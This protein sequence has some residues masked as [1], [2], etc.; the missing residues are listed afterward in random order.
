MLRCASVVVVCS[1]VT[2]C[3]EGCP[4]VTADE[5]QISGPSFQVFNMSADILAAPHL[6]LNVR[7]TRKVQRNRGEGEENEAET[8]EDEE[9]HADVWP[10]KASKSEI[11]NTVKG[12][13]MLIIL[14]FDMNEN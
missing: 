12:K 11:M 7:Y 3:V 1:V 2:S 4:T 10:Q 14:Q 6:N 8:L 9:H 5:R 13:L